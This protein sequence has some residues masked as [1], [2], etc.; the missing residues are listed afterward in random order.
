MIWKGD[1]MTWR[2]W[3][4]LYLVLLLCMG[5]ASVPM[6][7]SAAVDA[8]QGGQY[9]ATQGPRYWVGDF[10][11]EYAEPHSQHPPIEELMSAEYG[12]GVAADGYVGPRRGGNN[13]WFT[14]ADPVESDAVPIYASGIREIAEQITNELNT[15]GLIGVYVAPHEEDVDPETGR[16]LRPAGRTALRLVIWTG[17]VRQIRTFATGARFGGEG[18]VDNSDHDRII[19]DSPIGTTSGDTEA[20]LLNKMKLDSYVAHLN[21]YPGRHVDVV[22]TPTRSP[23][24]VYVDYVIEEDRP[25]SVY[26]NVSNTGTSSTG[27]NRQRLG[28]S[29]YQLTGNDDILRLDY[30]TS[31]GFSN[32]VQGYFGSYELALPFMERTRARVFAGSSEYTADQVGF[33]GDFFSGATQQFGVMVTKNVRQVGNS[34]LDVFGGARW[35][36]VEV[37]NLGFTGET[38]FMIPEAGVAYERRELASNLRARVG[39]ET[40]VPSLAGTDDEEFSV[41]GRTDLDDSWFLAN[42]SADWSIFLEPYFNDR[43]PLRRHSPRTSELAHELLLATSGQYAFGHRLIPQAQQA[44]G[45]ANS[46]RGYSQSIVAGDSVITVKVEYRYHVPMGFTPRAPTQLPFIG[47]F[48]TGPHQRY[49]RPDWDLILKTFMDYGQTFVSDSL[50]GENDESLLGIGLGAELIVRRNLSLKLDFGLAL[51][52]SENKQGQSGDSESHF[53]A[54]VRY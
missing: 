49:R 24:E 32:E 45:G 5:L 27:D 39:V 29:H 18:A 3:Q 14:L 23:G 52:D 48:H 36:N 35:M 51:Q 11:L 7:A 38:P 8:L 20:D 28:F 13:F 15:R 26:A 47:A 34:F 19:D 1:R 9:A 31:G 53:S 4:F 16:D 12:L 22:I 10:K 2:P 21:R 54:T 6:R 40:S 33:P 42:W 50:A 44:L 43:R 25:W 30:I 17:R 37:T 46:V 41:W